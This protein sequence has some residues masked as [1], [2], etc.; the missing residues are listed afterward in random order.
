MFCREQKKKD[1]VAKEGGWQ[2]VLGE[3]ADE[4]D[5]YSLGAF[6]IDR[7]P[8]KRKDKEEVI[9]ASYIFLLRLPVVRGGAL[10]PLLL[11]QGEFLL[12]D[13]VQ[14]VFFLLATDLK[15]DADG[16]LL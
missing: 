11:E 14:Q 13:D 9:Q 4:V 16:G 6:N 3:G 10:L 12:S 15:S 5:I 1:P 2:R 7:T 8:L